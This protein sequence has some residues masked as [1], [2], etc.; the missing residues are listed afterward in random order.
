MHVKILQHDPRGA[1]CKNLRP[2]VIEICVLSTF[3]VAATDR[4]G[5]TLLE[6]NYVIIPHSL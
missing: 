5:C 6:F 4:F 1:F 3:W 2:S